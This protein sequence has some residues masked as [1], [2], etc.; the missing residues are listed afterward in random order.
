MNNA[1][2]LTDKKGY[3]NI[4]NSKNSRLTFLTL[5]RIFLGPGEKLEH[6]YEDFESVIILQ[7][8]DFTASVK[9]NSTG[10]LDSISGS[11]K[12]V[13]DEFPAVIYIPP[14][15]KIEME[16]KNGLDAIVYS[17]PSTKSSSPLFINQANIIETARGALNWKRKVR[18]IFGPVSQTNNIIIGESVSVP[19]GWIGFPPHKHD[20]ETDLENPLDEIYFFKV[21]GP[22]GA[23]ALHHTY[24]LVKGSEEHYTISEDTAIAIPGGFHTTLAVPG[25]RLYMLWGLAGG[26]KIYKLSF[27]ERFTWLNDAEALYR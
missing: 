25:C 20:V 6:K 23:Y 24:D 10:N 21:Q 22:H 16:T 11:R 19:G 26:K 13:F 17:S 1:H 8:G 18:V 12:D 2:K 27:D 14:G 4:V 9:N 5:D 3:V 15:S 7:Q